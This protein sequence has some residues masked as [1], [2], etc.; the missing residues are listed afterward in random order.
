MCN[1]TTRRLFIL[2]M[3]FI[4][5]NASSGRTQSPGD[6]V[7]LDVIKA[8]IVDP[9]AVVVDQEGNIFVLS[10]KLLWIID[11]TGFIT[12]WVRRGGKDLS[13]DTRGNF[14]F[15]DRESHNVYRIDKNRNVIGVAGNGAF[16]LRDRTGG[17][18][19]DGGPAIQAHLSRPQGGTV[20]EAGNIY[21]ADTFN[22]CV[23]LV[24]TNGIIRTI[25]GQ[26][27]YRSAPGGF[28]GDG[29]PA[30]LARLN[31]PQDVAVDKDGNVYIADINNNRIR[32]VDVD[33]VIT[34][35]AG[36]DTAGFSGDGGPATE[37][38][39]R[40]PR[41]IT[42]DKAG[43]LYIADSGNHRIRKVKPNGIICT[44]AGI[45]VAGFAGDGGPATEAHLQSPSNVT[46]DP[47]GNLYI[48]DKGNE[49]IRK[50]IRP[51]QP[52]LDLNASEITFGRVAPGDTAT[53]IITITNPGADTLIVSAIRCDHPVFSVTDSRII[54]PPG[55]EAVDT[56]WAIPTAAGPVHAT[57][58]VE[59]NDLG[60]PMIVPITVTAVPKPVDI[61]SDTGTAAF[62]TA[63]GAHVEIAFRSGRPGGHT[64][65]FESF[66]R[67]PPPHT[68]VV[69][70]FSW[71]IMYFSIETTLPDAAAFTA[72]VTVRYTDEQ[73]ATADVTNEQTLTAAV[74]DSMTLIWHFLPTILDPDANIVRFT[75]SRFSSWALAAVGPTGI[76]NVD[77]G[78][79]CK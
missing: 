73:L 55:Q 16:S 60:S 59:S 48:I 63:D 7:T 47:S 8:G 40:R 35:F 36:C 39:L 1:K 13:I 41:G 79:R 54:I 26:K 45:G 34:T 58:R 44:I 31:M 65:W 67:L 61:I 9:T 77:R 42:T 5:I 15:M 32:K 28:T 38:S 3:G 18:T 78:E 19:G 6:I 72:E 4:A 57:L 23:R 71:P 69:A 27:P 2:L 74:F 10:E 22:H 50:V 70:G 14:Y 21:I 30:T 29:G 64:L 75:T 25:A 56:L 62:L 12:W 66:G 46:I 24:D 52:V 11:D 53:H 76:E 68:Q 33:G 37:A 43:T 20:D 17:Y 51:A 49:R